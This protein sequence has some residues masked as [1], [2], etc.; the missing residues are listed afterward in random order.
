MVNESKSRPL[1]IIVAEDET[2]IRMDLRERLE[3]LGY[4]VVADASD[5]ETAVNLAR[6]T[7]PDL[8]LMDIKMP[9]L[10]GIAAAETL[11]K[12]TI[13][14]VVLVTAF[15][16]NGLVKSASD[17][18]VMA[19]VMKPIRD[20]DLRPA[21]EVAV[22]RFREYKILAAEVEDLTERL[23]TRKVVER[24]KGILMDKHD[25]SEEDSFKR[26]QKLSMDRRK[27]MK[28]I[29]EAILLAEDV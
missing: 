9:V 17:V 12:E 27:T 13:A 24:A 28:D 21:I 20:N 5:G 11:T 10:D 18:G 2:I 15:S 6:Q 1:R 3:N 23:E 8:V 7:R 26:I 19:Y 22:S 4:D 29:A 25:L 16:D 14:P